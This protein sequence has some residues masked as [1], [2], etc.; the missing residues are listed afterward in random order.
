M[1]M[2]QGIDTK[3]REC[4]REQGT[5]RRHDMSRN[6]RLIARLQHLLQ[7]DGSRMQVLERN[8]RAL[9]VGRRGWLHVFTRQPCTT[10]DPLL[11]P[12]LGVANDVPRR[13]RQATQPSLSTTLAS[14]SSAGL[15]SIDCNPLSVPCRLPAMQLHKQSM[16]P[17]RSE[18]SSEL[19]VVRV[20]PICRSVAHPLS[21]IHI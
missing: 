12:P 3:R 9:G 6:G 7:C 18:T 5:H 16:A 14:R 2:Q 8:H 1:Q 13:Q 21:L 17:G 15:H 20:Q 19:C 4:G 11:S 10:A